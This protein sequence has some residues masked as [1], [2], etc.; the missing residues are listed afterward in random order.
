MRAGLL[1]SIFFLGNMLAFSQ[2]ARS[3]FYYGRHYG[4]E[5]TFNPLA[6][7]I[8]SGYH[9]IGG[10]IIYRTTQEW[11]RLHQFKYPAICG[12]VTV[13]ASAFLNEVL[14]NGDYRGTNVDPIADL[15][16]F[17]PLGIILFSHDSVAEFFGDSLHAAFWPLQPT[18]D[19]STRTLQNAGRSFAY[20]YKLPFSKTLSLFYHGGLHGML[21]LSYQTAKGKNFSVAS[22]V[23]TKDLIK[24]ND[25]ADTRTLTASLVRTMGFFYDKNN[26]LLVS[27]ILSKEY[28]AKLNIYPGVIFFGKHS[29]GF[30]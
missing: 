26:S 15:L 25:D 4:S 12:L 1:I 19:P 7:L 30:Y 17:D 18:Y 8:N 2:Q 3:Y 10:G 9:M 28:K 29:P 22:G 16:V 20:K 6:L 21:G 13:A 14:E 5:A 27:F 11:Y 23:A 24:A